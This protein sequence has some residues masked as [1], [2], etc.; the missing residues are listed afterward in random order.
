MMKLDE[1]SFKIYLDN[2]DF[3]G[4]VNFIKT[5]NELTIMA[6]IE[7]L[8]SKEINERNFLRLRRLAEYIFIEV[9]GRSF[10]E[11]KHFEV[12]N[13]MEYFQEFVY[14]F[15]VFT[16][17]KVPFEK[18]RCLVN[19]AFEM[20]RDLKNSGDLNYKKHS[21]F[22]YFK[23]KLNDTIENIRKDPEMNQKF[24]DFLNEAL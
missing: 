11:P 18:W 21:R 17:L 20:L 19:V 16:A 24:F 14:L 6:I 5:N 1:N 8:L 2:R 12:D 22:N 10:G 4:F 15:N 3:S 9:S 7:Q 13:N 23:N